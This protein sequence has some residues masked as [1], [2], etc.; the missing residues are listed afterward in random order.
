MRFR[1]LAANLQIINFIHGQAFVQLLFRCSI[2][3]KGLCLIKEQNC[4]TKEG[5]A[6]KASP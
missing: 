4:S 1:W 3:K 5:G 2:N 6:N